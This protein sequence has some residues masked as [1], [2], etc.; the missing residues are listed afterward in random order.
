MAPGKTATETSHERIATV[1]RA[2]QAGDE[3]AFERLVRAYQ[4]IAVA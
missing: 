2:A 4:D 1:V 3:R